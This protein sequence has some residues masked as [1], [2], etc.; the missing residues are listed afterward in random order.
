M[1]VYRTSVITPHARF[2]AN[3]ILIVTKLSISFYI[4]KI[5]I[6]NIVARPFHFML[7]SALILLTYY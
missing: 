4:A 3:W 5:K 1:P 7:F 6:E 2:R